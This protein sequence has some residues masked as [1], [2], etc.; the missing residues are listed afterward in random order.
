MIFAEDPVTHQHPESADNTLH[1][2]L[3]EEVEAEAVHWVHRVIEWW[4][5]IAETLL[6][7]KVFTEIWEVTAFFLFEYGDLVTKL[8]LHQLEKEELDI[9]LAKVI[10]GSVFAVINI[11]LTVQLRKLR[12]TIAST[13]DLIGATCVLLA[14]PVIELYLKRVDI[15]SLIAAWV[16]GS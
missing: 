4:H 3:K 8:D 9:L 14:S 5:T 12:G 11:M 16:F 6:M 2:S 7:I 10:V 15:L 1:P 13:L